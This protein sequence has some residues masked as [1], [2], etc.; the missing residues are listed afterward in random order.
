MAGTK[1]AT[2]A[3]PLKGLL[4]Q[5]IDS[6]P[7]D[8]LRTEEEIQRLEAEAERQ[9]ER[10]PHLLSAFKRGL[11]S[12]YAEMVETPLPKHPGIEEAR[13]LARTLEP[14]EHLFIYGPPG[15]A[16]THLAIQVAAHLIRTHGLSARFWSLPAYLDAARDFNSDRRP[17]PRAPDVLLLDEID[18]GKD[19]DWV[20]E[21]LYELLQRMVH[22]K[23][24]I[25]TSNHTPSATANL[26]GMGD[27]A[28]QD[29]I[30][31]RLSRFI[32]APV[33]GESYRH[34]QRRLT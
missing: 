1:E 18:K 27:E 15:N 13:K 31:S 10:T 16:K 21:Q 25:A 19:S 32:P 17:D 26:Y 6:F 24:I 12:E 14:G 8:R 23:T 2:Q 5:L 34:N 33:T 29:A 3:K 30:R 9:R 22:R 28:N 4:E 11:P 7:K 20:Y